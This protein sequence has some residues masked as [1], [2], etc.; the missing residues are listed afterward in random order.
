MALPTRTGRSRSRTFATP[1]EFFDS[2]TDYEL[3]EDDGNYVLSVELPGFDPA[4]IDLTWNDGVLNL[5][6]ERDGSAPRGPRTTHRRF[7]FPSAVEEDEI[8]AS[9]TNGVL[10]VTL[11]LETGTVAGREIEIETET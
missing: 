4:E 1:S 6:A 10:E 3:Y 5:A 8:A 11:P 2:G 7:R 9:Y